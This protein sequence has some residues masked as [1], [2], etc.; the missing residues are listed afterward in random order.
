MKDSSKL[1]LIDHIGAALPVEVQADY[2]REMIHCRSLQ[3]NDEMLRIL[4]AMQ[5]LTLLMTQ[6]PERVVKERE[7]LEKTCRE[8]RSYLE[9]I[10]QRL[11]QLPGFVAAGIS[12]ETI[13]ASVDK[14]LQ[15]AFIQSA[16][17]DTA[18]KL[19]ATVSLIEAVN[20]RFVAAADE[21]SNSCRGAVRQAGEAITN[22]K[23]AIARASDTAGRAA[24]QLSTGFHAQDWWSV[25]VLTALALL[26]GFS[27]GTFFM[28]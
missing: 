23:Q 8:N 11:L 9:T 2:Y 19:K 21:L 15:E 7:R 1:N 6:V 26:L 18:S 12:T 17:P 28:R 20:T 13:V 14:K 16:I 5:F 3:E 10:D 25:W 24:E 22:M 4:R 27:L